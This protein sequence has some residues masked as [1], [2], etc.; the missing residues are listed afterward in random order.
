[1]NSTES[2]RPAPGLAPLSVHISE[3]SSAS[4]CMKNNRFVPP[5]YSMCHCEFTRADLIY[6]LW[7]VNSTRGHSTQGFAGRQ[8]AGQ[9]PGE[10][11]HSQQQSLMRN[12]V[13]ETVHYG[14]YHHYL[15]LSLIGFYVIL[16]IFISCW[17]RTDILRNLLE[18][19]LY[20]SSPC[21]NHP[22]NG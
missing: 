9:E 22:Q 17:L 15:L 8:E 3:P 16:L 2:C 6:R 18:E 10:A 13:A 14:Y 12:E 7:S 21:S 19:M 1:M 11:H 5:T 20:F 4:C